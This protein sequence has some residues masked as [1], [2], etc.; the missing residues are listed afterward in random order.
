SLSPE[1]R[2]AASTP[3]IALEG[4]VQSLHGTPPLTQGSRSPGNG[5]QL[6]A[7]TRPGDV[8]D[9]GGRIPPPPDTLASAGDFFCTM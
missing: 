3:P 8:G 7:Y 2:R 9:S 5:A 6:G 4:H 1:T